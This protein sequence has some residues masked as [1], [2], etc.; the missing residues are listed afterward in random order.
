MRFLPWV[1]EEFRSPLSPV[2]IQERLQAN[3]APS[4][5]TGNIWR[6]P[7]AEQQ[8][9]FFR[10]TASQNTFTI[11]RVIY[12]KTPSLPRIIGWMTPQPDNLGSSIHVRHRMPYFSLAFAAFWHTSLLV[13]LLI[14]LNNGSLYGASV[15]GPL[16]MLVCGLAIII[17]P[18]WF[19]VGKS[20]PE[21]I[22]LLQLEEAGTARQSVVK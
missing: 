12:Y 17:I 16:F 22:K 5:Y 2:E 8:S 14:G 10:G 11:Q 13:S 9:S 4:L 7:F 6:S 1:T 20:R 21:L 18:F 19:E 3:L 15:L